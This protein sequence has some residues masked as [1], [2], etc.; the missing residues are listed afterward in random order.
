[1]ATKLN[2]ASALYWLPR[3][4]N[5]RGI[6]LPLPFTEMVPYDHRA[7]MAMLENDGD[8]AP[9]LQLVQQVQE[10]GE[11]M[12]Y[13][14]FLRTDLASA[15]HDGPG[16]YLAEGR[17]AVAS[18]LSATIEDNE[19][20]F[21]MGGPVPK[22]ILVR[23]FLHLKHYFT[24]YDGLPIAREYRVFVNMGRMV[25]MHPYWPEEAV[26]EGNPSHDNWREMMHVMYGG[27][28]TPGIDTPLLQGMAEVAATK[29]GG[30]WSVDFAQDV[31]GAWW[32]IDMAPGVESWHPEDCPNAE[33]EA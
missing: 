4:Q 17:S 6:G 14:V 31:D 9:W 10:V 18:R 19:A 24:A 13:P 22:A 29:C 25:C 26:E 3:L 2:A 12:G 11:K 5:G 1:V 33:G 32:L 7:I 27:L 8:P 30:Y 20:K 16:G 23:Q 15:K 28:Q 21:W